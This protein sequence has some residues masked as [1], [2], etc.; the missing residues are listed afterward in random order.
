M[1]RT[2][3]DAAAHQVFIEVAHLLRP[4]ANLFAPRIVAG[5]LRQAPRRVGCRRQKVQ[6]DW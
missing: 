4:P 1:R 6:D 2:A 3:E 5:V